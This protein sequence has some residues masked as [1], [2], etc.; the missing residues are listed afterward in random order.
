VGLFI[1][2]VIFQLSLFSKM[3][4][5]INFN[6]KQLEKTMSK[7]NKSKGLSGLTIFTVF[8]FLTLWMTIIWSG[9]RLT[10][11]YTEWSVNFRIFVIFP[12]VMTL[13]VY[14]LFFYR[15]RTFKESTFKLHTKK[16]KDKNKIEQEKC[17]LIFASFVFSAFLSYTSV[18]YTAWLTRIFATETISIVYLV[19]DVE[20]VGSRGMGIS[21][22]SKKKETGSVIIRR[23]QY[24][25]DKLKVGDFIC[26]RGRQS[27]FGLYAD[28]IYKKNSF[29]IC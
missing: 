3:I 1:A 24:R 18:A 17:K 2:G 21:M 11:I 22:R 14:I 5:S 13:F 15:F 26:I 28:L 7:G 25:E 16:L 9:M 20:G 8:L 4:N 29:H 27:V 23:W 19:D 6:G 10:Y 12:S